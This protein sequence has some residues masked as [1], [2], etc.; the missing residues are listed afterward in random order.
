MNRYRPE[1]MREYAVARLYIPNGC[2]CRAPLLT[3]AS[4]SNSSATCEARHRA[5]NGRLTMASERIRLSETAPYISFSVQR[6]A[7]TDW[8]A[9]TCASPRKVVRK[10]GRCPGGACNQAEISPWRPR[11]RFGKATSSSRSSRVRSPSTPGHQRPSKCRFARSTRRPAT[12][13][14]S[15][16]STRSP[17]TRSRARPRA[18]ATSTPRTPTSRWMTTNSTPWRSRANTPSKSTRSSRAS[19]STNGI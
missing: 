2:P 17:A 7:S 5:G 14:A 4:L 19:R 8:P 18:G 15:N 1:A 12:A 10:R 9:P 13:F 16:W 6:R 11:V 3:R